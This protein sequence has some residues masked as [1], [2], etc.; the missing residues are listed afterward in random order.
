MDKAFTVIAADADGA[1]G[2]LVQ[3]TL[4]EDGVTVVDAR[5][6]S[7]ALLALDR[8]AA[9]ILISD[10]RLPQPRALDLLR[11]VQQRWPGVAVLLVTDQGSTLEI[12]EAIGAGANDI[13]IRP[14]TAS[15]L[16]FSVRRPAVIDAA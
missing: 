1:I 13:L 2:R 11:T 3:Q 6:V 9:D 10:S 5:S 12:A 15:Q 4:A 16:A 8:S 7:Q 14:V